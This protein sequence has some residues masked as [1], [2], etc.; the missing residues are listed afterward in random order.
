MTEQVTEAVPLPLPP[1]E[2]KWMQGRPGSEL[3]WE[4]EREEEREAQEQ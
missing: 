1:E 4:Q 3:L 2:L